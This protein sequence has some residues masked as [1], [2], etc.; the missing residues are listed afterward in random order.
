VTLGRE[1]FFQR[2]VERCGRKLVV[3]VVLAGDLAG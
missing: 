3:A 2:G 1:G